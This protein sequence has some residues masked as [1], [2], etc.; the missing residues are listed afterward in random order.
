MLPVSKP[1]TAG[2][3]E[4]FDQVGII[5]LLISDL[6]S[7]SGLGFPRPPI[8][9][10]N[11]LLAKR[12]LRG[13]KKEAKVEV[14]VKEDE[15]V[16]DKEDEVAVT[17][18]APPATSTVFTAFGSSSSS[19]SS[20]A[21]SPTSSVA[22]E[23]FNDEENISN[24]IEPE[25]SNPFSGPR[26]ILSGFRKPRKWPS[27]KKAKVGSQNYGK[28]VILNQHLDHLQMTSLTEIIQAAPPN[29]NI[30]VEFKKASAVAAEEVTFCQDFWM[31]RLLQSK[32]FARL[33]AKTFACQDFCN[34]RLL[35]RPLDVKTFAI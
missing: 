25:A 2:H 12:K 14:E 3:S 4:G 18:V 31:S 16:E 22:E 9:F 13:G 26:S 15:E 33:F 8:S 21:L 34:I 28:D 30:R 32:T 24:E 7:N 1:A 11:A 6:I 17:T 20:S 19:S 10:T 35:S 29:G 5:L 27:V 23:L